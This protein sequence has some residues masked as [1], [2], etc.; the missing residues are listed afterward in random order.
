MYL[1]IWLS[2]Y[3]FPKDVKNLLDNS[4]KKIIY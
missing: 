4:A 2:V 1:Y 3:Q